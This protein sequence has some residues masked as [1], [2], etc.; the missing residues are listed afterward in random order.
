MLPLLAIV[1]LKLTGKVVKSAWNSMAEQ[2]AANR[3][4]LLEIERAKR[5]CASCK[6][7]IEDNVAFCHECGGCKF[8]TRGAI[9]D[10]EAAELRRREE[11]EQ[12]QRAVSEA[13]REAE[14]ERRFHYEDARRRCR[15]F[16]ALRYCGICNS[17]LDHAHKFCTTCGGATEQLPF[18]F[19]YA[20]GREEFPELVK[21]EDDFKRLL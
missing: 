7:E 8:T 2:A 15:L 19:A 20:Y 13:R 14:T 5:C 9:I 1:A 6:T 10:R 21:S 4:A 12:R 18:E 17:A 11:E 16:V 3:A